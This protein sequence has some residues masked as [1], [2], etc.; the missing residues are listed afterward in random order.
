M[1]ATDLGRRSRPDRH[2]RARTMKDAPQWYWFAP[3]GRPPCCRGAWT[4][5]Q[6]KGAVVGGAIGTGIGAI[7][8]GSVGGALVGGAVG[9]GV[10]ASTSSASWPPTSASASTCS[11]RK[12]IGTCMALSCDPL[13]AGLAPRGRGHLAIVDAA[14]SSH[15]AA[16][17]ANQHRVGR[18][19][20]EDQA[21]RLHDILETRRV[22]G[23]SL[24]STTV[25]GLGRATLGGNAWPVL[26]DADGLDAGRLPSTP[27]SATSRHAP[28]ALLRL[29]PLGAL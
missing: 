22:G 16:A 13:S 9:A 17:S 14:P 27:A 24:G 29:W 11:D 6:G 25:I 3:S 21:V 23:T 4:T 20:A 7:A 10:P 19:R 12:Y 1:A 8:S 18:N 2:W 28:G 15:L 5:P 26:T